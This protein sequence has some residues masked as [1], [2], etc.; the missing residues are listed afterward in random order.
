M[1]HNMEESGFLETRFMPH[2]NPNAAEYPNF[3]YYMSHPTLDVV[4]RAGLMRIFGHDEW[5][6]RL[7]GLIGC[8]GFLWL[9]YTIL[10]RDYRFMACLCACVAMAG[11]PIFQRLIFLSMH[12]P[13]TLFTGLIGLW[14]C[15]RYRSHERLLTLACFYLSL[16]VSMNFDWPG[17]FLVFLIW[18][19]HLVFERRTNIVYGLPL[20]VV[21]CL[22]FQYLHVTWILDRDLFA[23]LNASLAPQENFV[24]SASPWTLVMRHQF[25]G[26]SWLGGLV[27]LGTAMLLLRNQVSRKQ[28]VLL[29]LGLLWGALN[30]LFFASKGPYHDFWGCYW[31]PFVGYGA[32]RCFTWAQDQAVKGHLSFAILFAVV[33]LSFFQ[34]G[35]MEWSAAQAAQGDDIK[36]QALFLKAEIPAQ[37]QGV[38][39]TNTADFDPLIFAS[40]SRCHVYQWPLTRREDIKVMIPGHSPKDALYAREE[41]AVLFGSAIRS[42]IR[43]SIEHENPE[44]CGF[45]E[46]FRYFGSRLEIA[47]SLIQAVVKTLSEVTEKK[48]APRPK[49]RS[50]WA[51]QDS[52]L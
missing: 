18:V 9:A 22:A 51:I 15:L 30:Y 4:F 49:P 39:V 12:H 17:Y 37:D 29:L 13:M 5:V 11:L 14:F 24:A 32:L 35:T 6:V 34:V 1:A 50:L 52:N 23:V 7:P 40:Y 16:F 47:S 36:K 10:R 28:R 45:S 27:L 46:L 38:F 33:A 41:S 21:V 19:F 42:Q 3:V 8:F 26:F 20:L 48:E 31:I 43:G 44:I 25:Q 2:F